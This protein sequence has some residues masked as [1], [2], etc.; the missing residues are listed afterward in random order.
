MYPSKEE[1][2]VEFENLEELD[3]NILADCVFNA[4]LCRLETGGVGFEEGGDCAAGLFREGRFLGLEVAKTGDEEF[5]GGFEFR[6]G[7]GW[8]VSMGGE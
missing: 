3:K 4:D 2:R 6:L 8:E 7:G 5:E 1:L